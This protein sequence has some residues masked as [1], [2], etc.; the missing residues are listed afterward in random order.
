MDLSIVTSFV[1]RFDATASQVEQYFIGNYLMHSSAR[2]NYIRRNGQ[3]QQTSEPVAQLLDNECKSH[4]HV[5]R[6]TF[7]AETLA[8]AVAADHVKPLAITLTEV[9]NGPLTT[10]QTRRI[11]EEG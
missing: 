7:S 4:T 1:L 2:R 3:H 5:T 9:A 11:R 10:L 6:S 8:A